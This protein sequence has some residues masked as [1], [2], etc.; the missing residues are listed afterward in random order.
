[1]S[2]IQVKHLLDACEWWG[3]MIVT[4]A[5][6]GACGAIAWVRHFN[7]HVGQEARQTFVAAILATIAI[8]ALPTIVSRVF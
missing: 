5:A 7:I 2:P 8:G 4:M 1:M 6:V 3:L